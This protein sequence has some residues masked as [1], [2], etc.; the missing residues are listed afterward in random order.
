CR[1]GGE[2]FIVGMYGLTQQEGIARLEELLSAMRQEVFLVAGQHPLRVT[3]STGVAEYPK[4]GTDLQ[5]LYL[6]AD[7]ALYEAKKVGRDR[8]CGFLG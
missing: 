3:F 7:A 5:K 2:E 6:S 1:W 4:H 8:I